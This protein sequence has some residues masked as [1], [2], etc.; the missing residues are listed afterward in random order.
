MQSTSS[1]N[2]ATPSG[3]NEDRHSAQ[4][5]EAYLYAVKAWESSQINIVD[6]LEAFPRFSTKRSIARFLVKNEIFQ[7]IINING[8]IVECGVFN[9]AGLFTWASLSEIYEPV[10]YT[11]K[12][13]GF[14]TF[15]GF[16]SVSDSDNLSIYKSKEGDLC[17][18]TIDSIRESAKKHDCERSLGHIP[19]VELVQGDFMKTAPEFIEKNPHLLISLLYLDFDL[20]EPT[21][22]ALKLFTQR[23]SAGSIIAFDEL[24]CCNFP[25][26]TIA[27]LEFIENGNFKLH[28]SQIDPWISW[29]TL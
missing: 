11:R 13:I 24:N 26:E 23:M 7:K 9:G 22:Q 12:I 8:S 14:D 1:G 5:R 27:L 29:I 16:P 4:N 15:G 10:N 28:R 20:Y 19:K 25:G 17:G 3:I 6:K 2:S 21:K 18:D